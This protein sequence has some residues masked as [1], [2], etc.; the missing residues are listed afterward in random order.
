MKLSIAL[1]ACGLILY[2]GGI[3]AQTKIHKKCGPEVYLN[4]RSMVQTEVLNTYP[5]S[6]IVHVNMRGWGTATFINDSTLITARHVADKWWLRKMSIYKNIFKSGKVETLSAQLRADDFSVKNVASD[7]CHFISS[8]ISFIVLSE[9]GKAKVR[10]LYSGSL[11]IVNY[12]KLNLNPDQ[13]VILTG[14]PVDLAETG[15]NGTDI[16]SDKKTKVSD[17]I[18]HEKCDMVGYKLFTCSGDSGAPLWV[19][20]GEKYYVIG[21]HHGGPEN[22][23]E[24][25][26]EERNSA[27]LIKDEV[28][29]INARL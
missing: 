26:R 5:Y 10:G 28:Y 9:T 18:F 3:M 16:L 8:D 11:E 19:K 12:K 14:Y 27:A 17:L 24:F 13:E 25:N 2:S 1:V 21:I 6:A 20:A 23:E 7:N 15:V 29:R 4:S 22:V